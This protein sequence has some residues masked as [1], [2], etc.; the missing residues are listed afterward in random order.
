MKYYNQLEKLGCKLVREGDDF[1][2]LL[3]NSKKLL[4]I[5]HYL[6]KEGFIFFKTEK[7]KWNFKKFENTILIDIDI[8]IT[9]EYIQTYFY[10][11]T[12]NQELD[13]KYFENPKKYEKCVNTLR[14][15]LLLRG[16]KK[17]YIDFFLK[18][19]N[20]IEENNF[21]L[22]YL[23]KSPFRA[24][25]NSFDDFIKVV[26]RKHL[27]LF[28]YLRFKYYVQYFVVK[29]RKKRGKII[30][31]LGIDGSG[32]TTIITHLQKDLGYQ[33]YYLGDRSIYFT[34]LYKISYLKPIS[35]FIQYFE[36]LL[37]V[38]GIYL[39][40]LR[41]KNVITDRYYYDIS[42]NGLKSKVYNILYNKLFIKPDIVIVLWNSSEVILK[43]KEEV[44]AKDIEIF[45][46]KI[47]KLPFK[48]II[49]I[50]NDDI[51]RTL[52]KI[53]KILR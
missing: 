2:F 7:N 45:N 38:V 21:C 43:R 8:S 10:D 16:F 52:N 48:N 32:K 50:K 18:N 53:L 22:H 34:K 31:F 28:K 17:K 15:M 11:I 41:G 20:Y 25:F 23:N 26:T 3:L 40:T 42:H 33:T 6:H 29:F 5:Y 39:T 1:D 4:A 49:S 9:T 46:Q 44:S 27:Y 12:I 19:K 14:Y 36:K 30:T 24:D 35:I 13:K 51:D 47:D 37:R